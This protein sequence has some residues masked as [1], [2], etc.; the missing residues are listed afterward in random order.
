[1]CLGIIL[2]LVSASIICITNKKKVFN[3]KI[4]MNLLHLCT[5]FEVVTM[6]LIGLKFNKLSFFFSIFLNFFI[7][8]NPKL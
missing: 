7:C 2:I 8:N 5:L 3:I 1:M 4:L 6:V